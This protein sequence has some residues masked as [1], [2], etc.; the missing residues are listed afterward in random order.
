MLCCFESR[1][2]WTLRVLNDGHHSTLTE[3]PYGPCGSQ[4]ATKHVVTGA[5]EASELQLQKHR[6]ALF[7]SS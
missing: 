5:Q 2:S 3:P 1:E 6:V 4:R 7:L